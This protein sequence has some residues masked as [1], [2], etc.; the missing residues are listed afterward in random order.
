MDARA[1]AAVRPRFDLSR[2]ERSHPPEVI[3]FLDAE[4][5]RCLATGAWE[6]APPGADSS[7]ATCVSPALVVPRGATGH[8]LVVD[9]RRLNEFCAVPRFRQESLAL[10]PSLARPGDWAWSMDL[11]DGYHHVPLQTAARPFFA[12]RVRGRLFRAAALPFGWSASPFV[13]T[14]V[15]MV[16]ARYLRGRGHRLLL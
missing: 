3:A 13:F 5:G 14:K 11:Q 1:A 10:L 7:W 4:I 2:G 15:M 12:F 16:V 8:R 6:E 9:L